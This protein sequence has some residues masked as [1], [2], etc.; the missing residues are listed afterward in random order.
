MAAILNCGKSKL[1][2]IKGAFGVSPDYIMLLLG[3]TGPG[4]TSFLNLLCNVSLIEKL[5]YDEGSKQLHDFNDIKLENSEA[6][7]MESKTSG[8]KLYCVKM[9]GL[10]V[11]VIDTPGFGD[12]RG[13]DVDQK[14]AKKIVGALKGEDYVNCVCLIING[15]ASR[16][17]AT[18]QYV[19]SEIT[20]ILPRVVLTWQD[21]GIV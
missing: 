2:D 21:I 18:L 6:S 11:G 20:A 10:R 17:S 19:L 13:T 8:A 14:H 3:E 9:F 16:M 7:K 5:G 4:K 15:R 12:T 1:K